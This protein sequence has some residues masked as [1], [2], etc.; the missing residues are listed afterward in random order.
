[1]QE[2]PS[3]RHSNVF[4]DA[5]AEQIGADWLPEH[6]L[7]FVPRER[8][9]NRVLLFIHRDG[10]DEDQRRTLRHAATR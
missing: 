10:I 5:T 2:P 4:G 6:T 3:G 9:D 7:A 8:C 1:M